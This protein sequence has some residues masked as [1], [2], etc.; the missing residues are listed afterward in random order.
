MTKH[1]YYTLSLLTIVLLLV[2]IFTL[3]V[4]TKS[5]AGFLIPRTFYGTNQCGF[6]TGN[7]GERWAEMWCSGQYSN[8]GTCTGSPAHTML[9]MRIRKTCNPPTMDN[10]LHCNT[11]NTSAGYG[12]S[13]PDGYSVTKT[14]LAPNCTVTCDN[15][16]NPQPAPPPL[17]A[18][19]PAQ[20]CP[21]G[22][23]FLDVDSGCV[24][25]PDPG[26]CLDPGTCGTGQYWDSEYCRCRYPGTPIL[27]DT[28]GDGFDLTDAN[29][30]VNFDLDS[31]GAAEGLSWTSVGSDDAWLALDRNA[32]GT[33]DNGQELFGDFT[34]Q[35]PSTTPNGFL[36]LAEYDKPANGGNSDG[37]IDSNDTIFSSLRLWQDINHNGISEAN[38]LHMLSSLDVV[39]VN[40]KYK[41]SKRTDQYGNQFKYRAKVYDAQ[42]ARVGRWAWDVILV[43]GP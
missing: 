22:N 33:I 16:I 24:C 10:P 11:G 42:G 4:V 30:G 28:F 8:S 31:D 13:C 29:G 1:F 27:I 9:Y 26:P 7:G 23:A 14:Q 40:L 19:C 36:A 5:K 43:P 37:K 17:I 39:A 18:Q 35:P 21:P 25:N 32:N 3:L 2:V 41:V 34:P 20:T 6:A 38:E 12:Y 15:G